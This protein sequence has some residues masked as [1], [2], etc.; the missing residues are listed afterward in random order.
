MATYIASAPTITTVNTAAPIILA[1]DNK[2]TSPI[3]NR[4]YKSHPPNLRH[5]HLYQ[6]QNY[7]HIQDNE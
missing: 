2:I 5:H 3:I 4:N 7:I 6:Y 1:K